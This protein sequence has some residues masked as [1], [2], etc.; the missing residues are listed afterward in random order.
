MKYNVEMGSGA[1]IYVPSFIETC[2]DIQKLMGEDTQTHRQDGDC[3]SLL[4]FFQNKEGKA[5]KS[6]VTVRWQL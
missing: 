3:I 2:S 5:K 4:L 6:N 1:M